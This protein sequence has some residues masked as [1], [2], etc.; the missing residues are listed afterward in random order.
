[1]K[2]IIFLEL[3]E[4]LELHAS[5]IRL[6]GGAEGVRDEGLLQSALEV[7]RSG[8]GNEYFHKDIFEMAGAYLFHLAKNHPFVD[9]NKRIALACADTFLEVNGFSVT[10]PQD[11]LYEF[12]LKVASSSAIG[13]LEIAEFFRKYSR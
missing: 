8:F 11:E 7:P 1:M 3:E 10:I 9:G 12:V 13:K 4:V 5:L 2:D 6:C